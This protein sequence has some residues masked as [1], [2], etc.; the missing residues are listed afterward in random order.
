MVMTAGPDE[1]E[2]TGD[3]V[4]RLSVFP[5]EDRATLLERGRALREQV[6]RTAHAGWE[7]PADRPDP[8]ALTDWTNRNRVPELVP[9]RWGRMLSSPFA[10]YRGS[11]YV[12]AHDLASTVTSGIHVQ[13]CGDAHLMNFGL[14]AS[15]ER[16]LV[17]D[18]N[19]FDE[20]LPG[21]W[22]WDLKRLS[23]SVVVAGRANGFREA[24]NLANAAAIGRAYR[25]M[26]DQ[27]SQ[28]GILMVWYAKIDLDEAQRMLDNLPLLESQKAII[29]KARHNDH[30]R[31][32]AK[33]TRIVNGEPRIR[34]DPPLIVRI[35]DRAILDVENELFE[36]YLQSI[37]AQRR[38]LLR[39]FD[40]VDA[41]RK[42]VGV[43][44]VGTRCSIVLLM[45]RINRDP[46]FLQVKEAEHSILEPF[47]GR[48]E[49]EDCAQR[50]VIGQNT[51]QAMGDMMLGWAEFQGRCFYIRQ[52][53]DMKGSADTSIMT[54]GQ[55]H[56]YGVLCA[57]TL[58]RSHA[59]TGLAAVIS[60]YLGTST[61]F[62]DSLA[63]FAVD[64]ADQNERDY[65]RLQQAVRDGEIEAL[66]GF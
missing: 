5:G 37:P 55:L 51:M 49:F 59:R 15:P 29:D 56:D 25:S 2:S 18:V 8:V 53:R 46:L 16:H 14:Y 11:P 45:G 42:V 58:A 48:T 47:V 52:L 23:A 40:F 60:G 12:M 31:S 36:A 17:F 3:R 21:P 10:H 27:L 44:S 28:L 41:A 62:D 33:L 65:D 64:Y 35:T 63:Q 34:E 26:M 38:T 43:G 24:K 13:A 32:L 6:P 39:M 7:P 61:K 1:A 50:V 22:E 19:D 30:H 4:A 57:E 9:I 66:T 54:P 20:T